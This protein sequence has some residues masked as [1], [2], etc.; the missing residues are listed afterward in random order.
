MEFPGLVPEKPS[1]LHGLALFLNL[2]TI[3]FLYK[4]Y[5]YANLLY[6]ICVSFVYDF[7]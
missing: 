2:C 4:N 1:I 5:D 3:I 6:N 7:F